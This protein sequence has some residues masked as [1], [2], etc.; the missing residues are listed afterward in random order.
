MFFGYWANTHKNDELFTLLAIGVFYRG[1]GLSACGGGGGGGHCRRNRM[2]CKMLCWEL[3]TP[4][5]L[6]PQ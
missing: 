3:T 4:A 2:Q 5:W 1:E 6:P